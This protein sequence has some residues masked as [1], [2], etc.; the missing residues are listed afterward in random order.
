VVIVRTDQENSSG[1]IRRRVRFERYID[2]DLNNGTGDLLEAADDDT[3]GFGDVLNEIGVESDTQQGS[4]FI[5]ELELPS[6]GTK[7]TVV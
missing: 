6:E 5:D 2:R 4:I 3:V 1:H 7:L